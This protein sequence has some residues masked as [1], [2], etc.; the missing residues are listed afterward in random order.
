MLFHE[1]NPIIAILV[2]LSL[3]TNGKVEPVYVLKI[4]FRHKL[5]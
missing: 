2:K 1:I 5:K 4:L 3:H